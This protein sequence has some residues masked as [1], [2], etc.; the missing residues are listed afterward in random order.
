MPSPSARRNHDGNSERQDDE[1]TSER[2]PAETVARS[3][4]LRRH[5]RRHERRRFQPPVSPCLDDDPSIGRPNIPRMAANR[6]MHG[7]ELAFPRDIP[8]LWAWNVARERGIPR[9]R[10]GVGGKGADD[11]FFGHELAQVVPRAQIDGRRGGL[12]FE[13]GQVDDDGEWVF[14]RWRR[15]WRT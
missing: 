12:G 6:E 13:F 10:P 11:D 8:G 15:C 9:L 14:G 1:G 7:P 5:E 2:D 4:G 3:G